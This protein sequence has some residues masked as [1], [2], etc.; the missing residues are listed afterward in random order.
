VAKSLLPIEEAAL[1]ARL[2][3]GDERAKEELVR[4][5]DPLARANAAILYGN[6]HLLELEFDDFHQY[7]LVGLL[8]AIQRF[9]PA[10]GVSFSTYAT[11]RIKGAILNGVEKLTEKQQQI[12][13]RKRLLSDRAATLKGH[14]TQP[15]GVE[16][17]VATLA[18]IAIGLALGCMLEDSGLYRG[19][20]E[21][22][23]PGT[24][25]TRYELKQLAERLQIQVNTLPEK[26]RLIIKLHYLH[27]VKFEQIANELN[28]SKGRISQLHHTALARLRKIYEQGNGIDKIF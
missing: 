25:Y 10:K 7:A 18:D 23:Q 8:E 2:R 24:A 11:H 26:E 22:A 4:H 9:D 21:Q 15:K 14:A 6:R 20:P 19:D 12:L 27:G 3:S 1:W 28:L 16:E 5:Y 13:A 17:L